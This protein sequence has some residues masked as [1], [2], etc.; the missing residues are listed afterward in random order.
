MKKEQV[1]R[2]LDVTLIMTI[3]MLVVEGIFS[4]P[5]VN[6][7]FGLL[8]TNSEGWVLYVVIWIIMFLQVTILNI[9]AYVVLSASVSV[10]IKT[11]SLSY[12]GVVLSAYMCGC[13]FAYLLGRKYGKKA[14]KWC[15][16]SDDDY[17]K[18]SQVLNEKGKL[19]YFLTIL[20]PLFPDDVLC[21]VA[22]AVKFDFGFYT[23]ANLIGRGVGLVCM[24][25]ILNF[26]GHVG[27][28]F[29]FMLIVWSVA[30]VF[31]ICVI[32]CLKRSKSK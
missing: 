5:A 13:I 26:L 17:N 12:I 30:I 32:L 19:W 10:G 14:V 29:P 31:E 9:P 21:I 6:N 25:A 8:I 20:L 28:G 7:W 27:G 16:G 4:I 18:W 15:A 11:M 22:G 2:I 23:F 3:I 1:L 24:I